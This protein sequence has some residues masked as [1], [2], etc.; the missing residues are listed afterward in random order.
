[1]SYHLPTP[2]YQVFCDEADLH[3]TQFGSARL[4][5]P[6]I[7]KPL[8]EDGSIGINDDAV[9]QDNTW[10]WHASWLK[11]CAFTGSQHWQKS[12]SAGARFTPR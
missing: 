5:Y 6:L 2:R 11:S 7:V 1:M 8:H 4:S 12:T 9:V 10:D 3:M